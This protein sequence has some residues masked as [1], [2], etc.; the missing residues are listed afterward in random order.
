VR[1]SP[2]RVIGEMDRTSTRGPSREGKL[3]ARVLKQ[4]STE[5]LSAAGLSQA[6]A[7]LVAD[8]LV[9]ADLWGHQSHGLLRLQAYVA[10]LKSGA[11]AVHGKPSLV[12]EL[13]PIAVLDGANAMGQVVAKAAIDLAVERAK[14]FGIG[15]ISVRNSN[16]FGTAM[17][18][19]RLAARRGCI[20]FMA[21]NAS[22]AM[23]PWGGRTKAV[24]TNPW[25]WAAPAGEH[26]PMILDIANTAVARGK[27]HLARQRGEQIPEGWALDEQ[28]ASTT[29]PDAA[30]AGVTLPMAGHKGYGIALMMDVLAGVLSGS[31]FGP[32]VAGPFQSEKPGRVGHFVLA[33]NIEAFISLEEFDQR[34]EELIASI[35]RNKLAE[36]AAEI[37]Y[38]G[39]REALLADTSAKNGIDLPGETIAALEVLCAEY[40]LPEPHHSSRE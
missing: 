8:T 4:I 33:L 36:G 20:G 7:E 6:D 3:S 1:R 29:S 16:H 23:P 9:Q 19:T 38:P 27:I 32:D 30:L 26:V 10:R 34:Q 35:K 21:T 5:V 22:P 13:G 18:F 40:G 11:V 24:G 28:G 17:Y 12:R 25:S 2:S 14:Q 31:G 15:A 39:E 37:L